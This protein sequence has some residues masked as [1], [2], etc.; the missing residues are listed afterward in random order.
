[1]ILTI[2]TRQKHERR[3][4]NSQREGKLYSLSLL[5]TS[6]LSLGFWP[7]FSKWHVDDLRQ[8]QKRL[9]KCWHEKLLSAHDLLM[10]WEGNQTAAEARTR[11]RGPDFWMIQVHK[12]NPTIDLLA[13]QHVVSVFCCKR[14][15]KVQGAYYRGFPLTWPLVFSGLSY[16]NS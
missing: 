13:W 11:I 10:K 4:S 16:T 5:L 9:H 8:D 1:M 14:G 6:D 7:L 2:D 3:A 15:Q 12:G